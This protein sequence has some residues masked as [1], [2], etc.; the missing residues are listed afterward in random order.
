MSFTDKFW[1][2]YA[3]NCHKLK[4]HKLKQEPKVQNFCGVLCQAFGALKQFVREEMKGNR[5]ECKT[6]GYKSNPPEILKQC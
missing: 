2:K 6:K 5:E 3:F 4:H 1:L